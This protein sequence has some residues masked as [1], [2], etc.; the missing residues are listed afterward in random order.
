MKTGKVLVLT[1]GTGDIDRLKE[2]L[3][4]PLAKSI[5]DGEWDCA[6]LLPSMIT[7]EYAEALKAQIRGLPV[8]TKPLPQPGLE[9]DADACF[10]HFDKELAKLLDEGYG[11]SAITV[12]F[13]RGTKAMSAALVLAAAGRGIPHLRYVTGVRDRRGMVKPGLET[14]SG[15]LAT[16]AIAR[17]QLSLAGNLYEKGDYAAVL[18][19]LNGA[20]DEWPAEYREDVQTRRHCARFR[21]AWD[22]LNYCEAAKLLEEIQLPESL[23]EA[24]EWVKKLS[25]K[26]KR[27][28]HEAMSRWLT[29]VAWDVLNNGR[30]RLREHHYEDALIRGYRVLELIGQLSLFAYGLDSACLDE[31]DEGVQR[32]KKK[33]RKGGS[34]ELG[35]DGKGRLNAGR[36][37]VA[38]LLKLK[39]DPVGKKLLALAEGSKVVRGRNISI[40][41]HGFEAQAPSEDA[42]V[43]FFNDLESLLGTYE[44]RLS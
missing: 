40:L 33:L 21:G 18:E 24:V 42:L 8:Q 3:L 36:E 29:L 19:V 6:V 12:D 15:L 10:G 17:R 27:S 9:D 5:G 4:T 26:P 2:T 32:L 16:R 13:T 44:P 22:R 20:L 30:Q 23:S 7:A 38:R 14:I 35:I 39:G 37:Q 43:T 11:P 28:N 41:N 1:V 34:R 31:T 25:R